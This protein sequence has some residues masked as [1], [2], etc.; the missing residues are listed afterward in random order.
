MFSRAS[1]S[2]YLWSME[3]DMATTLLLLLVIPSCYSQFEDPC[4]SFTELDNIATRAPSYSGSPLVHDDSSLAPGWYAAP[5]GWELLSQDPGNSTKCGTRKP[6]Y[7]TSKTGDTST[8]CIRLARAACYKPYTIQTTMCGGREIYQLSTQTTAAGFCFY[9]D[10]PCLSN[11]CANG[12]TCIKTSGS[13]HMCSCARGYYGESCEEMDPCGNFTELHNIPSR[14]PSYPGNPV[15]HDDSTLAPGWYGVPAGWELF[16]QDPGNSTKCG[17]RKPIYRTSKSGDASTV[18]I[19]FPNAACYKPYTIRT[20]MCGGREIYELKTQISLSGFCFH[21][22]DPCLSNPCPNGATCTKAAGTNH[23]CSCPSGYYGANCDEIDPCR[24]FTELDNI[25]T[26]APGYPGNPVVHDDST[27]TPGWYGAPVGWELLSQDPGNTTKCGTRKPI[28]RTS[29]SGDASTVCIRFPNAACYNPYT[30]RTTMCGRREIYELKTEISLSGFCFHTD[31]PCLSNPCLNGATCTKGTGTNHICSCAPGYYGENCDE[32]DPCTNVT[33]LDNIPSRAPSFQGNP[34]VHD[35]STLAP[36]WYGAPAGWELLSQDPGNSTLCGT[37]K[38]IYRTSKSGDASTVCIRFPNAACYKPYTIRTT[39]CGGRE[40][41]ELKTEISLSGFCFHT[42]DPCLSNPCPNGAACTKATGTNHICSCPSGY[43]GDNC[44]EMDP[45]RNFTELD[46]IATRAPGYPGNPVVHDDSTLT[47]GWYG[48]PVGWELLSQ[49]PGNTTK[50][51]TRKPIYRTSK[52]GDASTVC[53]RFPNAACYNPYT[54]RTTMCGG[55][56]IYELSTQISLAGFCFHTDDPCL[57][58]PCLNGA[59]CT[60]AAGTNHICSCASGYY[61]DNCDEMDP[62]GNFTELDNIPS[63]ALSYPGNPVVHDDSTLAP[64]WYGAPAGWEL[65]DQDPGNSTKCGTRKPIYRTSKSGDASTVCIRFP[66]APCYKPYTIRTTMCGGREIYELRTQISVSGFCFHTDDPCLSNPCPNG[67]TCTKAAGTSHIC[68]CP[69]GYYGDNCDEMD[70]CRNFTELDNIATRAPGYPGNPVVHDDSTLTPGWYAAP[71]GW[72]LLSQ[73]PGNTTKCGTR[74]PIY[75]TSK[76]GDAS[77]VCIRFPNAACYNPYTI[78]TTMCGGREI[79]ELSTQISLAGFCFHTDDPCLSNPCLNGATCTKAAGTNHICSCASGY[80][81]DNCDEMDPCG[82]FTE[83]DNIPSRALSYPGNPVVHDD[84]TL[85]PGWYG[86][87]AGWELLDQDPGNSTKC[88]TRKPI[89][90]T[91]K[92]GDASTVC[93]RFPNAVCYNPY[94]IRTTMCGGREI[95]EL[96][97]QISLSGFCF[98]TD[99]PCLSNPCPNGATCTKA[100]GTSHICSCPAGYYGDNCD[101]MDPCGNFTE[102]DNI[103]SRALSYPG[104]PVVHDDSTLAPGWYGAPAGWELLDQ[105]PGNSTKCGTRKPIYRTSKSGDASTVCIRFPNAPCY[106]PYTIRTTMCGGREIYELRTQISLSGFCFH[107][108]DPCLSNPCPNGATCTKA[109]GTSHICSCP[110]GYY[111]DNC[112]EI[113]PCRNFTELDN[114]ATRAPGYPGNPVVHDDST[115]TPGWYGAPVGWEL[116]SQDPGN[117]TKCGTRKPIYRTSKSGDASTVCIRFPNAACYN[118]YTIRTKMCGGREIY[119]LSTQ[120]S[121]SGFCFHTDDPCLSNPCL[122]GATC[123]RATGTNHICSCAPGYYG[124]SCDEMD[125]CGNFTELDNIPSRDPSYPGNPVVH[126]DSTLAPGWYGAPAGWEL[127]DQ[128]PGNSTKCGTR[129]P[130]YRTS[131]SG[132]ASTVCIRFPN[133]ACYKP[134]T[135]RSTMCSGREI[136]ELRTQISLSGFCFHTDDPCL[137]NPCP[138]GATCTKTTGTNHI[139]SCPAGYY[140]DNCDEMD[141]CGNFTELD[142]IS[143]RAPGYPGNTLVRDDSKL[144]PGWYGAPAGWELLNQ[145]PGNTTTCGTRKPIYRTSKSGDASTVCI[146][147]PNAA[148]YKPYTIRTTMCGGRE[149][150][151]LRTETSLAGFCF[152]TDD[153]CLS[154]PCLNG[155]TCIKTAGSNHI[156][157]CASGYYG[158]TCEEIDPCGYFIELDNIA[159][160][161][162]SYPGNPVVHDDSTLAPGWYGAPAGWELLSQDPGNSAKCGTRKPI[163]RSSKSGDASTV[164]IRFPN[165]VCYN[166]YTIRT[167]MCGER[168]IYELST[169]T[170][171]AGFCFHTDDPCLSNPCANGATCNK[172]TGTNYICSCAPG[173]Y[174]DNCD[175]NHPCRNF[176]ELDN[177]ATRAPSYPGNP[178]LHNDSSLAPGWYGAPAGWEL[179]SEDPGSWKMCGTRKPIYRTSKDG[180]TSTVCIRFPNVTCSNPYTIRTTM[181]GGREIYEL[182]TQTNLAGFCFSCNGRKLDILIMVDESISIGT[183]R[184]WQ[185]KTF[186]REM[187][188]SSNISLNTNN[189]AFMEFSVSARVVFPLNAYADDKAAVLAAMEK[190]VYGIGASTNIGDAI[191]LAVTDV[192][193]ADNGDRP[194]ADNMIFMFTDGY[195]TDE[196]KVVIAAIIDQLSAKAE[197]F[198]VAISEVLDDSIIHT[199]ASKP[200]SEHILQLDAPDTLS[201]VQQEIMPC[202]TV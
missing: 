70:P 109:A 138:N 165:A 114:I 190:E 177:I 121:L 56:E 29:K 16:S 68:S 20:T 126:D 136:Y 59:T 174:G 142:D 63:R 181:C 1:G 49:D 19:R 69:A 58:N 152:H 161:A 38:P 108:D 10:D 55:R 37:R 77:T 191:K 150:Y 187:L 50:C 97:T 115:L 76:S 26:R 78:R 179:L 22:D 153:P 184:F 82:N 11:P 145:D 84:S 182:S 170:S 5:V 141:P 75:R 74:K 196:D 178:V 167:T 133:A 35:D 185:M 42:D 134:Y 31:D 123:T 6:I 118:P 162:P 66:N 157:S 200:G 17:T 183:T 28:Y 87:P 130:I 106:K 147:F 172:A 180:D 41:Y 60:K 52:S 124:N 148:C 32:M 197:V 8:V 24:N 25:A 13:N 43:Y 119:E 89:Y 83:L 18:C 198:V 173:Y 51:G 95:Y 169:Q 188:R 65:L 140:G 48:A 88:G 175:D 98:H 116:L 166:P 120:I 159:T 81:G 46:N 54:I 151:E 90:R 96:R 154:N 139:C 146:R 45:C 164:C 103:P 14:A 4:R 21:T 168:E 79:Y 202:G 113:D 117:T 86:A 102:L 61:G 128:D 186:Q 112:D 158:K 149:I 192:F 129:K 9:T 80:Y 47:P 34:V 163:Y 107:T 92:S 44:D 171:L 67:A 39:M 40:I 85:A 99:D 64:G 131:K 7:R 143:T 125:P 57:S 3:K 156:C 36:G 195:A 94:T 101:E 127:L 100:A 53:I 71:V 155:A 137:S 93:I 91:S 201:K 73:D 2:A 194:D 105:D 27:L 30:I 110:A 160:R 144:A 23:I 12:A 15:V 62:C 104:N 111:G 193:T 176:T 135:I 199:I 33:E 72:E 189:V 122:N 132:D